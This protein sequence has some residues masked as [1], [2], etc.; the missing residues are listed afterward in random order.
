MKKV[1]K[2]I[3]FTFTTKSFQ[4]KMPNMRINKPKP[5]VPKNKKNSNIFNLLVSEKLVGSQ[6]EVKN[7]YDNTLTYTKTKSSAKEMLENFNS[8]K[9]NDPKALTKFY[10][11]IDQNL[12]SKEMEKFFIIIKELQFFLEDEDVE[13]TEETFK[14][15][16]DKINSISTNKSKNLIK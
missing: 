8:K 2:T 10:N 15:F 7:F 5:T 6:S 11:F 3:K 14:V 16:I 4:P 9:Q 13:K 1:Y 12:K